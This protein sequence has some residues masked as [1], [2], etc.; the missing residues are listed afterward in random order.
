M[1]LITLTH[2][3]MLDEWRRRLG[4]TTLADTDPYDTL[5]LIASRIRAWYAHLLLTADARLLPIEEMKSEITSVT[6]SP[7]GSSLT[8]T[9]PERA[10]RPLSLLLDCW[11]VPLT[12]FA[13]PGSDI[14]L[15]QQDPLLRATPD[16]PAAI[17][18][19]DGTLTAFG[20]SDP[21]DP[22][23]AAAAPAVAPQLRGRIA[24]LRAVAHPLDDDT[25]TLHPSLL[26]TIPATI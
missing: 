8:I 4:Y 5:T 24:S 16:A 14:A 20:I 9:L 22:A 15:R 11:T 1:Q 23:P 13:L 25:Y 18:N 2:P 7:D 3:Q 26:D 10:L 19:P 12:Q 6:P 17:L 21:S